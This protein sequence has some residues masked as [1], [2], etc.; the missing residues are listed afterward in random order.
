MYFHNNILPGNYWLTKSME[1]V[2]KQSSGT[3]WYLKKWITY[4]NY[5]FFKDSLYDEDYSEIS[6]IFNNFICSLDK[7]IQKDAWNFFFD[8]DINSQNFIKFNKFIK[9]NISSRDQYNDFI[10]T[11][12]KFY[13]IYVMGIGGQSG[14]K[15]F[16]KDKIAEYNSFEKV[17]AMLN[18]K[19]NSENLTDESKKKKY[20]EMVNDFHAALRNERQIFFYYGFFHGK[21]SSDLSGFYRLTNIGKTI[22]KANFHELLLLWEH[23]KIKMVSQSPIADIQNLNKIEN[24]DYNKFNI[25]SHPYFT[26]LNI[27]NRKQKITSK[28]YQFVI[29]KING[30]TN[31]N[32]V[33]QNVLGDNENEKYCEKIAYSFNRK[34]EIETEDFLKELKKF[35]LGICKLSKDKNCNYFQF[36]SWV[37]ENSPLIITNKNKANFVVWNYKKIIDYLDRKYSELY[38][39]FNKSLRDKYIKLIEQESYVLDDST[40]YEWYKHII[41]FDIN[42]YLALIYISIALKYDCYNYSISENVLF[43]SYHTFENVLKL[44]GIRKSYFKKLIP[45]IQIQLKQN[46][47]FEIEGLKVEHI[48][49]KIFAKT[50]T[51]KN[52]LEISNSNVKNNNIYTTVSRERNQ[53]LINYLRTFYINNFS[54]PDT[55]LINC[56][57]CTKK[58][59][60]TKTNYAYLEFHHLIPFST[61]FGPDHYLNIFGIC[62]LCHRKLHRLKTEEK[63]PLYK[64]MS[65]NNNLRRTI[66]ERI[67]YLFKNDI[68]EPINLDF[69]KKEKIITE[70]QYNKYINNIPADKVGTND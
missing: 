20:K 65:Q 8:V 14:Y 60:L 68:L 13:F 17:L 54:D 44:F 31:I 40:K 61:E 15:K 67:S 51:E 49:P 9:T 36:T 11:A 69:L 3:L 42:L 53:M 64:S 10:L 48:E 23:Q 43:K 46:S 28:Q 47:I 70:E 41:N 62:P 6:H 66:I 34:S 45:E 38:S 4:Y 55:N 18:N 19:I 7:K 16:I 33:V 1:F 37:T 57:C 39:I 58:T 22:L 25:L 27:L 59:F 12:K 24:I 56:D 32:D 35:I 29:S 63:K 52:L 50:I 30:K 26:L 5:I 21:E 2:K